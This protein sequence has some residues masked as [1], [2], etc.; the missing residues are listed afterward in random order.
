VENMGLYQAKCIS[1]GK[2]KGEKDER[3]MEFYQ[4]KTD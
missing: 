2:V 4:V 1:T 3:K